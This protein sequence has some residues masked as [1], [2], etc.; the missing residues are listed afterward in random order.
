MKW[1]SRF[2]I[3]PVSASK[4]TKRNI[5]YFFKKM[6]QLMWHAILPHSVPEAPKESLPILVSPK[7][8]KSYIEVAK[9]L[10][11]E[12]NSSIDKLE[13]KALKLL[14]YISAIFG[15]MVFG[16]T[17]L[18]EGASLLPLL[19]ALLFFLLALV[20]SLRV[21]GIKTRKRIFIDSI[22]GFG[23]SDSEDDHI[24][25]TELRSDQIAHELIQHS[26]HNQNV[27]DNTA[28]ILQGARYFLLVG[29]VIGSIGLLAGLFT[30]G[31]SDK[32]DHTALAIDKLRETVITK[33]DQKDYDSS[34][35]AIYAQ[36]AN[37]NR[38]IEKMG[39]HIDSLRANVLWKEDSK[40]FK[41]NVN[42][43]DDTSQGIGKTEFE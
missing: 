17:K 3:P 39:L 32:I 15:F 30:N 10:Y 25:N 6:A 23:Y 42:L 1:Q 29:M 36:A 34:I 40:V 18:G 26:I 33:L 41:S 19:V 7:D 4:I 13:G 37:A 24:P 22:Y 14:S 31:N 27:A 11:D 35:E 5:G 38:Q 43:I 28:D 20:I 8:D 2:L 12:S 16:A 9:L 21:V